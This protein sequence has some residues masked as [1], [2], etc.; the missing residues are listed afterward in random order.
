MVER[1]RFWCVG[2]QWWWRICVL[3]FFAYVF[4]GLLRNSNEFNVFRPLN[5]GIHE[6]GHLIFGWAGQFVAI[7][8]G[9]F[10]QLAAPVYGMW[11]FYKQN[12]YF[13]LSLCFGWLSTNLFEISVYMNDART[14]QLPL[15]TV[16]DSG[17]IIHDWNHLFTQMHI[18]QFDHFIAGC[19]W[20]FAILSMSFCLFSAGW[21]IW[22]MIVVKQS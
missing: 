16:G 17:N 18:L 22:N 21:M 3:G 14:M 5:F 8:G 10:T 19:V 20:F 6:L 1:I 11:N 4:W 2:K 15:V 9:T 7:L 13:A 12:D